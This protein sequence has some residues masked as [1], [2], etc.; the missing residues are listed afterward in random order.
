MATDATGNPIP[1]PNNPNIPGSSAT[2]PS[3]STAPT[4]GNPSTYT[5][6]NPTTPSTGTGSPNTVSAPTSVNVA[7]TPTTSQNMTNMIDPNNPYYQKWATQGLENSASKGFT[8][9]SMAQTGIL[10]S[11]MQNA[12]PIAQADAQ[13]TSSQ[14]TTNANNA[15]QLAGTVYQG[16]ITQA[17]TAANNAVTLASQKNQALIANNASAASAYK[18]LQDNINSILNNTAIS[19]K[20]TPISQLLSG[21]DNQM[22]GLQQGPNGASTIPDVSKYLSTLNPQSPDY[23]A[24]S[25]GAAPPTGSSSPNTFGSDGLNSN[26]Y[27]RQQQSNVDFGLNPDGTPI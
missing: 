13:Q 6:A 21:F 25:T 16:A 5:N 27:T 2:P 18:D 19:D 8:N 1:D 3:N 10:N 11:V 23:A 17:D 26:G 7:N 20:Q 24:A 9:G 14:A 4:T 12:T 22:A 15:N